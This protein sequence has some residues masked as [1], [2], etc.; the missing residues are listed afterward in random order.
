MQGTGQV[1]VAQR[2]WTCLHE[3]KRLFD[4]SRLALGALATHATQEHI[5][6]KLKRGGRVSTKTRAPHNKGIDNLEG[7]KLIEASISLSRTS[8]V[9]H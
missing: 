9:M 5:S 6:G 8:Q 3:G 4:R 7:I 2:T 1:F